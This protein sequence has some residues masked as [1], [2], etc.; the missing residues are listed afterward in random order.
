MQVSTHTDSNGLPLVYGMTKMAC[1]I[2]GNPERR[3]A[4]DDG[5]LAGKGV[6][7]IGTELG[8]PKSTVHNHKS[9][10]VKPLLAKAAIDAGRTG[11]DLLK[12]LDNLLKEALDVAKRAKAKG[13]DTLLLKALNEARDTVR[14]MGDFTGA[15]PEPP[16]RISYQIV[17]EAGRP[18]AKPADVIDVPALPPG[19][20]NGG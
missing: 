16:T 19:D 14:L 5:L 4:V 3:R 20:A 11:N 9:R 7:Q 17:F 10:C 12:K 2:C 15:K 13:N 6:R 8:I 1:S 18:V